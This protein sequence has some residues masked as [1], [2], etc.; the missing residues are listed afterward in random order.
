MSSRPARRPLVTS[1]STSRH[2]RSNNGLSNYAYPTAADFHAGAFDIQR[3]QVYDTHTT[4]TFRLQTVDLTPTIWQPAGRPAG[5]CVR[6]RPPRGGFGH[7]HGGLL[8]RPQ[9][10]IASG[11][12]WNRLIEVQ[13]F[14]QRYV[15]AHGSTLGPVSISANSISRYITFSVP[16]ASLGG[17][18]STGW[19]FTVVLTGQEG[20]SPDQARGFAAT[21][22]V[23]FGVCATV[24]S[25]PHCTVDPSTV[26]KAMDVITPL[27]QAVGRARLHTPQ[28]RDPARRH[29]ALRCVGARRSAS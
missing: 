24:S 28:A 8:L 9:L 25:D 15:D 11:S 17:T 20:F 19:V 16:K 13:G 22:P 2:D 10:R 21:P 12:A 26:P 4:I 14:G 3:F 7:L 29:D 23:V 18:P 5:G 6:P 1:C 27:R